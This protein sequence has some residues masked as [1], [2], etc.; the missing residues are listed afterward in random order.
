MMWFLTVKA[1]PNPNSMNTS[2][3]NSASV[4][5][6]VN[7]ALLDGAEHLV[8]YYLEKEGWKV[9]ETEFYQQINFENYQETDEGFSYAQEAH[10]DGISFLIQTDLM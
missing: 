4:Q 2:G 9:I 5:C 8:R 6:W 7:F 10:N 3:F 1:I